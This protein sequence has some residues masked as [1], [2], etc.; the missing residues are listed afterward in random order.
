MKSHA[1]GLCETV[2]PRQSLASGECHRRW[3]LKLERTARP[4]HGK[5]GISPSHPGDCRRLI[6]RRR[7]SS[8][9][10][11]RSKSA[12]IV[13]LSRNACPW[14]ISSARLRSKNSH[15]DS[16]PFLPVPWLR[17]SI[18]TGPGGRF[19]ASLSSKVP[20]VF[21]V[22]C[23]STCQ[24]FMVTSFR[25]WLRLANFRILSDSPTY[26]L[27]LCHP[28]LQEKLLTPSLPA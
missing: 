4:K 21:T 28:A 1:T 22:P 23:T 16:S 12:S 26:I 19:G 24:T 17:I 18:S 20:S 13:S 5:A 11:R 14:E 7:V 25:S 2:Q 9:E 6:D 8:L 15:Q 27:A 3:N 10:G